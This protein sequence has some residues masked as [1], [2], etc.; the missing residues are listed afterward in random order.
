VLPAFFRVNVEVLTV[1][2]SM[3]SLKVAVTVV[4]GSMPVAPSAGDIELTAGAVVSE[5][6]VVVPVV[7][8]PPSSSPHAVSIKKHNNTKTNNLPVLIVTSFFKFN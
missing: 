8:V 7:V 2:Q 4:L 1:A 6:P 5:L 3:F